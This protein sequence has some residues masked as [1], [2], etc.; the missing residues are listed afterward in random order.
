MFKYVAQSR[1]AVD[2]NAMLQYKALMAVGLTFR[3]QFGLAALVKIDAFKYV[4]LSY[5]YDLS[6]SKMR[7]AGMNTHEFIIGIRA[8]DFRDNR[9]VPCSA[10]E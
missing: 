10:Y 4:S 9:P 1:I 5:A 2:I 8:C 6:M 7:Y 3:N